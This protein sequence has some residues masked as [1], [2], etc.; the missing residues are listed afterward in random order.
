MHLLPLDAIAGAIGLVCTSRPCYEEES[1]TMG[2]SGIGRGGR[3]WS[4]APFS[5][6]IP[7]TPEGERGK[8]L[9]LGSGRAKKR[10]FDVM[11]RGLKEP[12]IGWENRC[13]ERRGTLKIMLLALYVLYVPNCMYGPA[14]INKSVALHKTR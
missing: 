7:F 8:I 1:R 3:D 11:L 5:R 4:A 10:W 12:R 6:F 14:T 2:R 9:S 13:N